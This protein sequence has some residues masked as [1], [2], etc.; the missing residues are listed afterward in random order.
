VGDAAGVGG[1]DEVS[2]SEHIGAVATFAEGVVRR[3]GGREEEEGM[4]DGGG[5]VG[6]QIGNERKL[7]RVRE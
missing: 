1:Q 4:G 6:I 3:L 7:R 2:A 5:G